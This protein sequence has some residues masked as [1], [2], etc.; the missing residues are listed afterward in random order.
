[1]GESIGILEEVLPIRTSW[2]EEG[3]DGSFVGRS[4]AFRAPLDDEG[5]YRIELR[6]ELPGREAL[7]TVQ[8]VDVTRS[9]IPSPIPRIVIRRPLLTRSARWCGEGAAGLRCG[10][11]GNPSSFGHY[12][13]G[14]HPSDYG[15]DGW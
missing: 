1:L 11:F 2:M 14:L 6:A 13:G 7:M 5:R 15:Y 10:I 8:E 4:F 3:G 12:G 9:T